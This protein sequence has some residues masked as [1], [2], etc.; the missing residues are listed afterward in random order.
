MQEVV[1]V[2]PECRSI[3]NDELIRCLNCNAYLL[4]N[5]PWKSEN[6]LYAVIGTLLVWM[7]FVFSKNV[8]SISS[9]WLIDDTI[10]QGILF[11]G[12][13]GLF[14][15]FFKWRVVTRQIKSFRILRRIC[16]S[17]SN[18]DD[19][20]LSKIRSTIHKN[21]FGPFN[22]LIAYQRLAWIINTLRDSNTIGNNLLETMRQH[23]DSDRESLESSHYQIQFLIWLLPTV[24]FLGTVFGMTQAL[25]AFSG[26]VSK[27]SELGFTAGLTATAQGLGVAFHTTL[28]G[29]A[30]V[31][32]IFA[33]STI[34]RRRTQL[35]L[36][37]ADKFFL[38]LVGN[39]QLEPED[40]ELE[41]PL[42]I[43]PEGI[44]EVRLQQFEDS[45]SKNNPI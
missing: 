42:E 38:R 24:G 8:L 11:L 4:D 1:N 18:L 14:L 19:N 17:Q 12:I 44:S 33:I 35:L 10:S 28:M 13:F 36:E 5:S 26:V 23:A 40:E 20:T 9:N 6:N 21:R 39:L 2:C 27:G 32:P 15:L 16:D 3:N 25:H 37:Q 34:L 45:I 22:S 41:E 29:L 30:T 31:I 7:L 43:P